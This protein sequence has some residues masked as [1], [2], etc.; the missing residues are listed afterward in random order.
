MVPELEDVAPD[1]PDFDIDMDTLEP[2]KD[3][4]VEAE[5]EQEHEQVNGKLYRVPYFISF[6]VGR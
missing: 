1:L 4:S 3:E 2:T 5:C 6:C